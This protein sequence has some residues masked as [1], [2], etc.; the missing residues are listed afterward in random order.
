MRNARSRSITIGI[1]VFGIAVLLSAAAVFALFPG[2]TAG[3]ITDLYPP[4]L[5]ALSTG[6]SLQIYRS[7]ERGRA[8]RR[9]WATLTAAMG[10]WTLAEIVWT[11]YDFTGLAK[12]YPSWADLFYMTGDLLLFIFFALQ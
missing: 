8:A 2:Q 12:P 9:I 10:F 11:F 6:L 4:V 3:L 1:A 7:L 5:A